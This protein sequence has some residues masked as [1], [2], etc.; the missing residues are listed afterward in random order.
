[1][2]AIGFALQVVPPAPRGP[3]DLPVDAVVTENEVIRRPRP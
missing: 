2:V 3:A 1:M